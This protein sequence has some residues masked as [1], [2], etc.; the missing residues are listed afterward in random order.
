MQAGGAERTAAFPCLPLLPAGVRD[1]LSCRFSGTFVPK[2]QTAHF[3]D[4]T[5]RCE[6]ATGISN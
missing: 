5:G 3:E 2:T 1:T 6:V 4:S